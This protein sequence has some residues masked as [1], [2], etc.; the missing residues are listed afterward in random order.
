MNA[1][2]G[3]PGK[4][5]GETAAAA[6]GRQAHSN[7]GTALGPTYDTRV[8]LPSGKRPDAVNWAKREVRELKPDN[9]RALRRGERQVA[10]YRKELEAVTGESWTSEID[11][12]KG[13]Q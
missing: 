13:A 8:R 5:G 11:T 4:K 9:A 2:R 3:P 10:G 6:A 1:P 7:Y 12:Y